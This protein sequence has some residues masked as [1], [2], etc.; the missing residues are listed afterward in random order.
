MI[1]NPITGRSYIFTGDHPN[2]T[3]SANPDPSL[4]IATVIF[5]IVGPFW[6]M[7]K[8]VKH[9][10]GKIFKFSRQIDQ[11]TKKLA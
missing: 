1:S 2:E 10:M 6:L 5:C 4:T 9:V 11:R 7:Y 3:E 8:F